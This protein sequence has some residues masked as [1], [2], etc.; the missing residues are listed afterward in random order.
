MRNKLKQ[1]MKKEEGFTLVELLAVIVILGL[2]IAIAIPA[3]GS[4]MENA[5]K[6]T[7]QATVTLIE[8]A[9]RLYDVDNEITAAGVTVDTLAEKGYLQLR[10]AEEDYPVGTVTIDANGQ[11]VFTRATPPTDS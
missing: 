1:L 8:D 4:I 7:D 3:V 6:N 9:A 10:G 5:D 11:Y 2:I